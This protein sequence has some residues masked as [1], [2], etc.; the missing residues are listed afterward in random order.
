MYSE[1][2]LGGPKPSALKTFCET[3]VGQA[4]IELIA[5]GESP[6]RSKHSKG[7][8]KV[9]WRNQSDSVTWVNCGYA[10]DVRIKNTLSNE[11][12]SFEPLSGGTLVTMY[13]CGPTVYSFAHIGNFRSFLFADVLRRTLELEGF[14]VRQVMNI[15]DVGHMT[16][17]H[18]ADAQ[19]EDKLAKIA[20]ALGADPFAVAS[21][22]ERIFTEDAKTLGLRVYGDEDANVAE[23]HPQATRYIPEMLAMIQRLLENGFAYCDSSGQVYFEITKFSRYGELSGKNIDELEDGA[24]VEVRSEKRDPRDFALWKVDKKHLMKWDPHASE[25]WPHP[26]DFERLKKLVPAG[27]DARVGVGFPGWHIECSAMSAA[28][29]GEPIDIHTGGEDNI[30]PHHECERAQSFGAS[31]TTVPAP[32]NAHDEGRERTSF[33]RFWVHGRYLLVDGRK[34]SKRDGTFFTVREILDPLAQERPKLAAKLEALGFPSGKVPAAVLRFSLICN[35]YGQQMNFTLEG[36]AAARTNVERLQSLTD[37]LS[38]LAGSGDAGRVAGL[39]KHIDGFRAAL[40]DNLNMP[41][42][43]ADLFAFVGE[44][45][46]L[47][48]TPGEAKAA[49]ELL[50]TVDSVLGVLAEGARSHL[51]TE[52]AM[53]EFEKGDVASLLTRKPPVFDDGEIPLLL[54]HRARARREKDWAKADIIRDLLSAVGVSTEDTSDGVRWKR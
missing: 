53:C 21:H 47:E 50:T 38:E 18:L 26:S 5:P 31:A 2:R 7:A 28:S 3:L 6:D 36:L 29:L 42:A 19:G 17:D 43:L 39:S 14:V 32:V 13:S 1:P 52:V 10:R 49:L 9:Y 12:E 22:F 11:L 4:L 20:R 23:L 15:T 25:G 35:Q 16:E 44:V 30:F 24:R 46:Q 27:I 40:N 33:A 51:L 34:M 8:A 54:S 41:R 37:R 45:N 48:L